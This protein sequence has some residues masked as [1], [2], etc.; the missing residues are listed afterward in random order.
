MAMLYFHFQAV[1]RFV[2]DWRLGFAFFLHVCRVAAALDHE[3]FDHAV[4]N[5]TVVSG[6]LSHTR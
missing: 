6:R 2:G 3:F 1:V 4:E 5:R